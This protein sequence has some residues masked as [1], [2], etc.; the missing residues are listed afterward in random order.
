MSVVEPVS[1]ETAWRDAEKAAFKHLV[2]VARGR[3]GVSAFLGANPGV[4]NAWHMA[5]KGTAVEH[6]AAL[7]SRNRTSL[8]L[9]YYAEAIFL[10]RDSC[11]TWAMTILGGLSVCDGIPDTN[12]AGFRLN[13]VG[14]IEM[15]TITPPNEAKEVRTWSLRIDFDLVFLTG[16][17]A[18][19]LT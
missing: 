6:T 3:E 14:P 4:V 7:L 8:A 17:R 15:L 2:E 9:G 5:D 12:V 16:G 10:G 1:F 19:R 18:A 11:L 13:F